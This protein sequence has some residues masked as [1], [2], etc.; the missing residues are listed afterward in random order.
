MI[1]ATSRLTGSLCREVRVGFAVNLV[2]SENRTPTELGCSYV[3]H[4]CPTTTIRNARK[5]YT[6]RILATVSTNVHDV[7]SKD[8]FLK[9]F[10][11][12]MGWIDNSATRLRVSSCLLYESVVDHINYSQFFEYF[13]MPDTFNTWF[14]ITELHVWMLLVRSMAEGDEKGAAGRFMRNCI[15]ETMWN[16]VTTRAKQLTMDNPSAVRP[17]IQQLSEQFQAALISYDEGISYDDKALAAALWRRFLGGRCDDYEKLELLVGY[18][19]KQVSMLDQ[20]SRYDFAIK[21][22]IKWAPLVESRQPT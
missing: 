14:L 8:G 16:D 21:P 12:K 3:A 15:V 18:V 4:R 1:R 2:H 17:Q 9:R 7:E 5:I 20:L 11:K 10:I 6:G 22:A 19:R 13:N